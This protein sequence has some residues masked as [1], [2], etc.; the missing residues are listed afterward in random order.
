MVGGMGMAGEMSPMGEMRGEPMSSPQSLFPSPQNMFTS[1]QSLIPIPQSAKRIVYLRDVAEVQ[2]AYWERRSGYF[3]VKGRGARDEGRGQEAHNPQIVPAIEVAVLQE[4]QGSSAQLVPRIMKAVR[5]LEREFPG[6][7]FQVTYDNSRF[8]NHLTFKVW[9]EL[10]LAVLFTA[11]VVLLFLGEWRGTLIALITVPTSLAFATLMLVPF[12]FSLNSGSLVGLLLSIGRLVDD[13]IIDI[14]AVERYLRRGFDPKTATIKGIAEVRLAVIASTATFTVA[15]IP[16]LFCGGITELMY[17]ELVYPLIFALLASEVGTE[18]MFE[19]WSPYFTGYQM[20]QVNGVAF[21]LTFTEKERRKRSIWEI[22]DAIH[23][24]AMQTIPGVRR[25]QIKEM[26]VD[27]MA[28]AAAP[29]HL[30]ISG[31]DFQVLHQ[32]GEQLLQ[33]CRTDP[34]CGSISLNL[35]R[36]GR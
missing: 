8:V 29:I 9:E 32:M 30:I 10:G 24:E 2:D 7:K 31:P 25:V 26:G 19:S 3:Y 5:E 20:P 27:V 34:L 16:L 18:T 36:L 22:I 23:R 28:T 21:M 15:L 13:T 33:I 4:P 12:S 14:H 6:V 17:R 35:R 1:P 11:L